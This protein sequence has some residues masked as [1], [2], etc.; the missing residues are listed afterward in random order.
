MTHYEKDTT[1]ARVMDT[2]ISN[3]MESMG[4]A[5]GILYNAAM[6]IERAQ[7]FGAGRYERS[8]SQ[9]GQ[10]D[11][12]KDKKINSR[13]GEIPLRIPQVRDLPKGS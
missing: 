5:F 11:G 2:L 10:A 13:V 12:F 8:E 1:I 7:F 9:I 4:E 6:E 3:G